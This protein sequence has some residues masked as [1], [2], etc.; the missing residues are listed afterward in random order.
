MTV[1]GRVKRCEGLRTHLPAALVKAHRR[2][3]DVRLVMESDNLDSHDPQALKDAG[4]PV[5]GD[6]RE[7]LMHNKFIVID[8]TEVWTGSMN[9]VSTCTSALVLSSASARDAARS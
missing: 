6:R 7:G 8:R 3:V 9:I 2:G 1:C 4:V 5:L